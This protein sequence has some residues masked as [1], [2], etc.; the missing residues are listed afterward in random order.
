VCTDRTRLGEA[1]FKAVNRH[2]HERG[3]KV[4]RGTIVD[5]SIVSA[6]SSTKNKVG[7]AILMWVR[8][9]VRAI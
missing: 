3:I 5:A 2:L 4:S 8:V 7:N 1:L 9:R 6:P